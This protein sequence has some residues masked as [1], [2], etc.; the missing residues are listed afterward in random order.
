MIRPVELEDDVRPSPPQVQRCSRCK[1]PGHNARKCPER[2]AT[3]LPAPKG[4]GTTQPTA[5]SLL[6][7][8]AEL[9]AGLVALEDA[10]P[11]GLPLLHVR[12]AGALLRFVERTLKEASGW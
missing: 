7:L 11:E 8:A 10:A 12:Q 6:A 5:A 4:A 1:L 3:V 2:Y 9:R